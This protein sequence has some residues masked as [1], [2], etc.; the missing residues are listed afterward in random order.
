MS[1][2]VGIMVVPFGWVNLYHVWLKFC[3]MFTVFLFIYFKDWVTI[4]KSEFT[5]NY[6]NNL[7]QMNIDSFN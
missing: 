3:I 7:E 2:V 5:K 6:F 4:I 1:T